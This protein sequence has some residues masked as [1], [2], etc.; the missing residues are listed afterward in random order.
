MVTITQ[1]EL[2]NDSARIM[3]SLEAGDKFIV[4]RN[5]KPV[6]TLLPLTG[7]RQSVP[8]DEL[9]AALGDLPPLD[10][11]RLRADGDRF[12]GDEGDRLA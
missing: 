2:R 4:T 3:D 11:A 1:R 5:G 7:P 8:S 12:F 6:G 10:F 9:V